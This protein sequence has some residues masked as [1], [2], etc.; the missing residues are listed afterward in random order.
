[1]LFYFLFF[2]YLFSFSIFHF[3]IVYFLP[4]TFILKHPDVNSYLLNYLFFIFS[5]HSPKQEESCTQS[6]KKAHIISHYTTGNVSFEFSLFFTFVFTLHFPFFNY[7][8][9]LY[10]NP[11]LNMFLYI[12]SLRITFMKA[13]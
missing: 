8:F 3:S 2:S 6:Q 10:L 1:M 5:N 7:P 4:F 12:V 9:S 11:F 13:F